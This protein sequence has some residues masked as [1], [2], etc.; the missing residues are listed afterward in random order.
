MA[1]KKTQ[2][3]SHLDKAG[4]AHIDSMHRL[5]RIGS[6]SAIL[7][8]LGIPT[9]AG[10]YF[11]AMPDFITVIV[12]AAGLLFLFVPTA[13]SEVIAYTPVFG[14][15]IY[16]TL[17]TG[18]VMNL[19]LPVANNALALLDVE[20]GTEDADIVTSIAVSVSTFSTLLIIFLGVLL[21]LPLRPILTLPEVRTAASYIVP[22]LFGSL[23][24]NSIGNNI[25]G[26][27]QTRG[28]MK[29]AIPSVLLVIIIYLII[30]HVLKNPT[31]WALYQGI[32]ILI[33]LPVTYFGTKLLYN[34]GHIK[35]LLPGEKL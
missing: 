15:S 18:N 25:G 5:G 19:K 4:K 6:V 23:T 21:M 30:H 26:G 17:I 3:V 33:L 35:V 14:S 1:D 13:I 9:V 2:D 22:A 24:L 20:N 7:I 27:I 8:M 28:R 12:T 32:I 31:L 10:I 34:K 29:G 11:D 16:L